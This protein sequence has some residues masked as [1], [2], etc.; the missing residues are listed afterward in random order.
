MSS[1]CIL[2]FQLH[3]HSSHTVCRRTE[4][5]LEAPLFHFPEVKHA[6]VDPIFLA[7]K[8]SSMTRFTQG[9][10]HRTLQ[11]ICLS[12][13]S[14][15]VYGFSQTNKRVRKCSGGETRQ[16]FRCAQARGGSQLAGQSSRWFRQ[17]PTCGSASLRSLPPP[18]QS[19]SPPW[20][21]AS[22]GA[23]GERRGL[24]RLR[25][26]SRP[27]SAHTRLFTRSLAAAA[28]REPVCVA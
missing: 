9:F 11:S 15:T 21:L 27:Y 18:Q 17:W 26:V 23:Q 10:N 25:A 24:H 5:Q 20:A 1:E 22:T 6:N 13:V 14:Y 8:M 12:L 19:T 3:T 16:L 2:S 4:N 7:R 28:V